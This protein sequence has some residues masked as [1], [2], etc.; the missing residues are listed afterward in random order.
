MSKLIY[1]Y[2]ILKI[3]LKLYYY[4]YFRGYSCQKIKT[5]LFYNIGLN[6]QNRLLFFLWLHMQLPHISF[7]QLWSN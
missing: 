2:L 7:A 3:I 1:N 5:T 4:R 6:S